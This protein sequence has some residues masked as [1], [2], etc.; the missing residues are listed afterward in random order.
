MEQEKKEMC[1]ITSYIN[2]NKEEFLDKK[3]L[4]KLFY[5][6]VNKSHEISIYSNKN[7]ITR[8]LFNNFFPDTTN[9]YL[10]EG[11]VIGVG[12]MRNDFPSGEYSEVVAI[13]LDD[14]FYYTNIPIRNFFESGSYYDITKGCLRTFK[15]N[16]MLNENEE[17]S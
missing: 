5:Y 3:H 12:L 13:Y 8:L 4:D 2:L 11:D 10:S 9:F 7:V 16:K 14:K 17:E 1:N 6:R 15:L